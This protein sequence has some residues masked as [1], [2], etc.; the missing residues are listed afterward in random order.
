M[1]KI[2]IFIIIIIVLIKSISYIGEKI[3]NDNEKNYIENIVQNNVD[4]KNQAHL[5]SINNLI[6]AYEIQ[7]V[8][9]DEKENKI[10][11]LNYANYKGEIP[12]KIEINIDNY[13]VISGTFIYEDA[14]YYYDGKD[15]VR[16]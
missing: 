11:D 1:K 13:Q 5:I 3:N 7:I 9:N 4:S 6:K 15:I 10:T 12:D 14:T 16:K 8:L 2:I